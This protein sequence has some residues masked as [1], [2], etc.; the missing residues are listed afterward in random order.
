MMAKSAAL[1]ARRPAPQPEAQEPGLS[2]RYFSKIS[3][4]GFGDGNNSYA[5]S[6]AW[7]RGE[8]YVG[9]SRATMALLRGGMTDVTL[10]VW[11]VEMRHRVY[12]REFELEQ[13][14]AEIWRYRTETGAWTRV[15][16]APMVYGSDGTYM[17]RD[18]GYRA[19][20]VFQGDSDP[21]PA[22]YA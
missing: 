15:H 11:P 16:Q 18:L 3:A 22:L 6:M 4:N 21:E 2:R 5:H 8:L 7:F 9:T 20:V 1:R 14:R 12:S 19:M 10:D 13:A 17:S